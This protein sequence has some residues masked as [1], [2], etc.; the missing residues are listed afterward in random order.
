M[1]T[2]V[3]KVRS[4]YSA[5][6]SSRAA[7]TCM[8]FVIVLGPITVLLLGAYR[9]SSNNTLS[10]LYAL[11]MAA[12]VAG[13]IIALFSL[14]T[15]AFRARRVVL[16]IGEQVSIPHSGIKFPMSE[17]STV[18]VWTRCDPRRKTTTYLALLPYHVDG[19]V[20]AASIRQ[21][22][23]PAEVTDYVVRFPKGTQPSAYEL[24]DMVRQMRP[25]VYIERLGS[26]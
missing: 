17:L 12:P 15:I 9:T 5:I 4:S 22:G 14:G 20:T 18:K 3:I 8:L 26:V 1:P 7:K 16:V 11:G 13:I 21:R 23:I 2:P 24:V 19:E 10:L 6:L 25:T